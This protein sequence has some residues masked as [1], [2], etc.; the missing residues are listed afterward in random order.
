M[1]R[2]CARLG[3]G[4]GGQKERGRYNESLQKTYQI[5]RHFRSTLPRPYFKNLPVLFGN[6]LLFKTVFTIW[7]KKRLSKKI[8]F[9]SFGC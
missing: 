7:G 4:G 9:N 2:K 3:G 5:R 6:K 1:C 8:N